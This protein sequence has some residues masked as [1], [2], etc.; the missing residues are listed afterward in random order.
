MLKPPT[1]LIKHLAIPLIIFSAACASAPDTNV[2]EINVPAMHRIGY[3]LKR[4]Y[5]S[6]GDL[7]PGVKP[8]IIPFKDLNDLNK[9]TCVDQI[10]LSNLKVFLSKAR[11]ELKDCNQ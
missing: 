8:I 3:N 11:E 7:L 4:D 5:D 10:G 9:L 6:N 1:K 2:M